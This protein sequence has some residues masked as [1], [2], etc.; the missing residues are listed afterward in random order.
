MGLDMYAFSAKKSDYEGEVDFQ[1]ES[2]KSDELMYWRKH[3]ALHGWMENLYREKGGELEFNC[4]N[5]NLNFDDLDRLEK[6]IR[7]VGLPK[8]EGYFFGYDTSEE[9]NED[10][11]E[12]VMKAK[13]SLGEGN[14]VYYTSWW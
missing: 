11:L 7:A 10:D 13:K 4:V 1:C 6:D 9:V 12:F 5:L 2:D 14:K 8:T 3:N